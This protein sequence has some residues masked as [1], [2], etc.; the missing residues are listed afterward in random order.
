M[1]AGPVVSNQSLI[2]VSVSTAFIALGNMARQLVRLIGVRRTN[3][4][5][6]FRH[7]PKYAPGGKPR[8]KAAS[9][10]SFADGHTVASG[11]VFRLLGRVSRSSPGRSDESN[12][13]S[14]STLLF[15]R[16]FRDHTV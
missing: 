9:A 4:S 2:R 10:H 13:D 14:D 11:D 15:A 12:P 7:S 5:R 6:V 8:T 1:A 16:V 3:S